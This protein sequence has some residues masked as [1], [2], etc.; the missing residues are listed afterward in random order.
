MLR[1]PKVAG[2]RG[3]A[4]SAPENTLSSIRR[5]ALLGTPWIEFDVKLTADGRCILMHDDLLERTTNGKGPVAKMSWAQIRKLDAGGW[6]GV[7][8]R[9]EKVPSFAEAI[10]LILELGL[11]ANVEIKACPGREIETALAT[12]AEIR[13]LWPRDRDWPLLS[14]FALEALAAARDAAPEI[15]RG[16][17][18]WSRPESWR[19]EAG[20]LGCRSVHFS[21]RYLPA[22]L[23]AVRRAGYQIVSYTVNDRAEARQLLSA[24][25]D[26]IITDQPDAMITC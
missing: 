16:L 15:P 3:A 24:G 1:L 23:G 20:R 8:W 18:L 21:N 6:F 19:A 17:L 26:C 13:R 9:G 10:E 22:D 4:A 12:V 7:D 25:V 14:S 5:A 2:H 11:G